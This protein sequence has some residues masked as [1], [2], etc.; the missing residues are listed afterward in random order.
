M[1]RNS[2]LSNTTLTISQIA[3]A[4]TAFIKAIFL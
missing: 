4:T 1:G 3:I 2:C